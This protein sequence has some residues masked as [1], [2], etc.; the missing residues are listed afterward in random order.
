MTRESYKK[1][2]Y[3]PILFK[4]LTRLCKMGLT[5]VEIATRL[6]VDHSSIMYQIKKNNLEY[7]RPV[8]KPIKP[9]RIKKVAKPTFTKPQKAMNYADYIEADKKRKLSTDL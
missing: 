1:V 7:I 8:K 9:K 4:E 2:F 6:N 5:Y 3:N